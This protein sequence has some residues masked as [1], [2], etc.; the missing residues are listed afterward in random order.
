LL[1]ARVGGTVH[2]S[3]MGGSDLPVLI[4]LDNPRSG[5]RMTR[6]PFIVSGWALDLGGPLMA[7]VV[8]IDRELWAGTRTGIRRPDVA[9]AYPDAPGADTA[10]W[11]AELD[12]TD[13]PREEVEISVV[14]LRQDGTWWMEVPATV[15]LRPR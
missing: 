6:A 4:S 14:A 11:R 5:D 8:G 3:R 9:A 7:V 12:L 2:L 13:W 15:G 1:V 10:G